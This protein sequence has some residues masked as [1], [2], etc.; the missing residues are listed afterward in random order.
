MATA[1]ASD[2]YRMLMNIVAQKGI[3]I[4]L[5]TELAK[6]ESVINAIDQGNM[7]PPPLP[8][9]L[10]EPALSQPPTENEPTESIM[11]KYDNL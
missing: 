5:Y 7:M 3:E 2:R 6:A 9:E 1:T 8:P 11:G 10:S 4:D